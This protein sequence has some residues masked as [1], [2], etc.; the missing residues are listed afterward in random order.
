MKK[1]LGIILAIML[2]LNNVSLLNAQDN[3]RR[4]NQEHSLRLPTGRNY[5]ET[6]IMDFDEIRDTSDLTYEF[7]RSISENEPY[8]YIRLLNDP[9][10][11]AIA[12]IIF[13]RDLTIPGVFVNIISW[14]AN[15]EYNVWYDL[16]RDG[17]DAAYYAYEVFKDLPRD[18]DVDRVK[19]EFFMLERRD[20][21][22]GEDRILSFI[23]GGGHIKELHI[24][25]RGWVS[26]GTP[27]KIVEGL[28][29]EIRSKKQ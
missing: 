8:G 22:N 1:T 28:E 25:G 23:Q 5:Y 15:H 29:N 3:I 12:G 17:K 21:I 13:S 27:M 26:S 19:V 10:I 20:Y 4:P 11:L 2:I 18:L 14:M 9:I 16:S 6:F 7:H 24:R